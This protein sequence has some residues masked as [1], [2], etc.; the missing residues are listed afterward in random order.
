MYARQ[1]PIHDD[2]RTTHGNKRASGNTASRNW[3][4]WK[5][6]FASFQAPAQPVITDPATFINLP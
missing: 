3:R 2:R 1:Q 4:G 5:R 6:L